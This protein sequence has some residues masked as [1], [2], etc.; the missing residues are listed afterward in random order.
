MVTIPD[1]SQSAIA[2]SLKD[3]STL[4]KNLAK[5]VLG[6]SNNKSSNSR[7]SHYG[8]DK[9]TVKKPQPRPQNVF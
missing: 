4:G 9:K 8:R 5:P 6:V 1:L 3:R 2:E 7:Q